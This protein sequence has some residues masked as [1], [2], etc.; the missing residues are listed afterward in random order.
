M[1][2]GDARVVHKKVDA[3]VLFQNRIDGLATLVECGNVGLIKMNAR[4]GAVEPRGK[5]LRAF[6][7]FRQPEHGNRR[8][9]LLQLCA[10]GA[11][12]AASAAGYNSDPSSER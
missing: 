1:I 9:V 10:K 11:T 4:G 12:N 7:V 2:S 5:R 6:A 3:A 8:A